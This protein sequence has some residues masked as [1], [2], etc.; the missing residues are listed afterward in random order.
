MTNEQIK[1]S[2]RSYFASMRLAHAG[3]DG[4]ARRWSAT[5]LAADLAPF[6]EVMLAAERER[7]A[8][9]C[10]QTDIL[11][12]TRGFRYAVGVLNKAARRIRDGVEPE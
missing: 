4:D 3:R 5:D 2:L 1:E 12:G 8:L 7:C 11:G 10:E 6:I 9:V